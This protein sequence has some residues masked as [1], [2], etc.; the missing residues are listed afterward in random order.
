ML[1]FRRP[2]S[3]P[4]NVGV[5]GFDVGVRAHEKTHL[6]SEDMSFDNVGV[7]YDV[8]GT[9]KVRGTRVRNDPKQQEAR[10]IF[11]IAGANR[12]SP[13]GL[14]IRQLQFRRPFRRLGQ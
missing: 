10:V 7:P 11:G 4:K 14:S 6:V 8:R 12:A 2:L 1:P 3:W 9:A 13:S 5:F